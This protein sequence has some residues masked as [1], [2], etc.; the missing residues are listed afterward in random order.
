LLR[1]RSE[2]FEV[3]VL[4]SETKFLS[5]IHLGKVMEKYLWIF[6]VLRLTAVM[7]ICIFVIHRYNL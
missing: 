2:L 4:L 6:H 3:I 1:D 5:S 7:S